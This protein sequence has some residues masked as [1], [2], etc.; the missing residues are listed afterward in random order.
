MKSAN[1]EQLLIAQIET[2]TGLENVDAIAAVEGIDVLWIG[3]FD[4]S[5][6]MG[7][8]GQFEHPTFTSAVARVSKACRDHGK[9]GGFMSSGVE[10]ARWLLT[11]G[12]HMQA[13]GGDLWL[14]GQALQE[15]LS[16][17]REGLNNN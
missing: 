9:I 12:F 3:H 14:Y 8:P 6:S 1:R 17:V 15:G 11:Q 2:V 4:L 7:I 10:N 5:T 13:F 16:A